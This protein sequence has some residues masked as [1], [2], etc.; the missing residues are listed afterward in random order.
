[1]RVF[2]TGN[3]QG[4]WRLEMGAFLQESAIDFFDA[5]K[6]PHAFSSIFK[7]FRILEGCDGII[8]CLSS[9]EPQHLQTVLEL[10]YASKLA[11]E[12]MVVDRMRR[13]TWIHDLPYARSF[14]HLEGLKFHLAQ[15]ASIPK[16]SPRLVG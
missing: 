12:I 4:D 10:G 14:P 2:L 11:K 1:M 13:K 6:Y 16:K 7:L 8:A 3:H 9:E 15:L 5:V